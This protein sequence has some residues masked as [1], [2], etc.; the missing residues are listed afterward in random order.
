MKVL[1]DYPERFINELKTIYI[2]S[3]ANQVDAEAYTLQSARFHKDFLL[4]TLKEVSDRNAADVLRGQFVM[5][6]IEHA[7][8]LEEGEV[9]LYELIGLTVKTSDDKILGD[10]R[11]VIETGANDVY[12]VRSREY[13]ELLLPIHDET[14]VEIDIEAG[15][16]TVNL[17]EG[18]LPEESDFS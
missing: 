13:G 8:P 11:D 9:Y 12:V 2:G 3:D 16:V 7:V 10:I 18:L 15:M 14:L 5:I 4:L 1:T 6:D 17:P